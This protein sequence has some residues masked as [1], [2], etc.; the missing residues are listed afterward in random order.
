MGPLGQAERRGLPVLFI[1]L[2]N[3]PGGRFTPQATLVTVN[4]A[5]IWALTA[6][7]ESF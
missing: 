7:G 5:R 2:T 6:G 1:F 4:E 3:G